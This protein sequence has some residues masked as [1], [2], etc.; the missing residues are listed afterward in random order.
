MLLA[1]PAAFPGVTIEQV[2]L[3]V[4]IGDCKRALGREEFF[5]MLCKPILKSLTSSPP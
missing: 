5:Q 1:E 4:N 3:A 2:V